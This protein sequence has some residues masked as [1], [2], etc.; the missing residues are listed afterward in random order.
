[1][2]RLFTFCMAALSISAAAQA[3]DWRSLDPTETLVIETSKGTI[4]VEMRPDLAPRAV[5]RIKLLAREGVYDGLLFHRVI[6]DFVDQTGNPDNKDGGVSRHP[7]L[8]PEFTFRLKPD[9]PHPIVRDTSDAV[10]GFVGSTPFI[11]A[12]D[13]LDTNPLGRRATGAYCPGVAGMGRQEAVTTANSE[14][15]FMRQASRRLDG[16]Y[17]V[18]GRVV[19]GLDVVRAMAV[20]EPP[21]NPDRMIRVRVAADIPAAERP[22]VEVLDE[23]GAA[24]K[25]LVG[26][27]RAARG[28]DFTV[29]D[30]E[31]PTR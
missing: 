14:I 11:G 13:L 26:R 4:V 7:D 20:G 12:Q 10:E 5:E 8:A 6:E 19:K 24:F 9:Q 25:A 28:A 16:D 22:R 23:R 3:A 18:W 27:V 2:L 17:T 31:I 15:F 1:M 21:A 30:I 29:C